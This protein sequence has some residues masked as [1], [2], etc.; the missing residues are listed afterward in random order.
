MR[1]TVRL[2]HTAGMP[3]WIRA[4]EFA[5]TLRA[6][7]RAHWPGF[8]QSRFFA[9][10]LV[11]VPVLAI[12][13][14]I[15][16]FVTWDSTRVNVP[17]VAGDPWPEALAALRQLGLVV[18]AGD[19]PDGSLNPSCYVV[20]SQDVAAG[21]RV[22]PKNTIVSLEIEADQRQVPDVEGMPVSAA[23]ES[24]LT[25]CFHSESLPIWCVPKDFSGGEAAL[26]L[27]DLEEETGF[28][29]DNATGRLNNAGLKPD[30][31][32]TVCDQLEKASTLHLSSSIVHLT[33]TV[34]LTT[35]PQ[36]HGSSLDQTLES[37]EETADGCKLNSTVVATFTPDPAAISGK[38]LPSPQ[39][40]GLWQVLSLTPATGHAALCD[41]KVR[42]EV[43]WPSTPMPQLIGLHH[44]P[45]PQSSATPATVALEGSLLATGCSGK[46]TVTSQFPTAGTLVPRGTAISCVAE[47]VMPNVVG[48]NPASANAA[49]VAAGISA[50]GSG[51]GIV[52][53][54]SPAAGTIVSSS[55]YV[56]YYAEQPKIYIGNAYFENCTAAR[57]AGAAPLYRGDSGY[58][59]GLDRDNDGVACE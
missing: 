59:D 4:R 32:W 51:D 12:S 26:A 19:S 13:G 11:V 53:T 34:P 20:S 54:Q 41:S 9:P 39:E 42:V 2:D 16:G 21:T 30:D 40:T 17:Q 50:S 8:R 14:G 18:N 38:A 46:G 57:A 10:V 56:S 52:V 22:E 43:E 1:R 6:K 31:T 24:L 23:Q 5:N 58:R 55:Q 44:V 3:W 35:V 37:L 48:L 27:P 33:L 28:V 49:L 29:F 45:E 47:L 15:G 7:F 25:G 36:P